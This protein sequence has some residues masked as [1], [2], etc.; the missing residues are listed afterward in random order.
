LKRIKNIKKL[1]QLSSD[2]ANLE[3]IIYAVSFFSSSLHTSLFC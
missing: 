3:C 1:N 2:T